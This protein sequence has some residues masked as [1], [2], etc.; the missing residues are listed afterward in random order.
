MEPKHPTIHDYLDDLDPR[1]GFSH[2]EEH[3]PDPPDP[4]NGD[5]R[6][7]NAAGG[8]GLEV[9]DTGDW[10][11]CGV[12]AEAIRKGR[13]YYKILHEDDR[14]LDESYPNLEQAQARLLQVAGACG[15]ELL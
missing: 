2:E 6:W 7:Y 14:R 8:V 1:E 13:K 12:I 3:C 15:E 9:F 10:H 11:S 4:H 5:Y